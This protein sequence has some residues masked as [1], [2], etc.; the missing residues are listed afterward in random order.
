MWHHQGFFMCLWEQS[1]E[2][3]LVPDC[4]SVLHN[5]FFSCFLLLP[6][7]PLSSFPSACR[8]CCL[9]AAWRSDSMQ[10]VSEYWLIACDITYRNRRDVSLQ[11]S[12]Q[13]SLQCSLQFSPSHSLQL[14]LQL[15]AVFTMF[16]CFIA[17]NKGLSGNML[18]CV[19]LLSHRANRNRKKN[20]WKA[21]HQMCRENRERTKG[22]DGSD[23]SQVMM[24][25]NFMQLWWRCWTED[26]MSSLWCRRSSVGFGLMEKYRSRLFTSD[27]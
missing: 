17:N 26:R 19:W 8:N 6:L 4:I 14:S 18:V 22:R 15:T 10:Y 9:T 12:L 24:F 11:F 3:E 13:L 1:W 7:L 2:A 23:G 16:H 21:R 20:R 5:F 27:F 25:S